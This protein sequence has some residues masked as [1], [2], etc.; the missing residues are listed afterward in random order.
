MGLFDNLQS[1]EVEQSP[2]RKRIGATTDSVA[3]IAN[4]CGNGVILACDGPGIEADIEAVGIGHLDDHGLDNAPDGLSIWEGKLT[5]GQVGNGY[6]GYDYETELVGSFRALTEREWALL[7]D[8]GTPWEFEPI[9]L[10]N[11]GSGT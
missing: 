11:E 7:R 1:Q 4:N 5:G 10:N 3:L 9:E 8:T 2:R 6:D